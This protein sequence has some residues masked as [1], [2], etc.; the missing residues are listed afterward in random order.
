MDLQ[1]DSGGRA[2]G[3]VDGLAAGHSDALAAVR[4][5]GLAAGHDVGR[6]V[7]Q[8]VGRAV[9]RKPLPRACRRRLTSWRSRSGIVENVDTTTSGA[10][11]PTEEQRPAGISLVKQGPDG[12]VA[13]VAGCGG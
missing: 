4:A 7:A 13:V 12:L 10:T 9:G 2:A 6:A 3:R 5:V 1:R 11:M 8:D